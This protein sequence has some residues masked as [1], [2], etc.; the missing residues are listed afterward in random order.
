M[1][2][3]DKLRGETPLELLDRIRQERPELKEETLSYAGRLDPM[4]EGVMLILVG[5]QENADRKKHLGYDKIYTATFLAGVSTDTGDTL[6]LIARTKNTPINWSI[7]EKEIS[8]LKQITEQT[9]PWFSGKTVGGIK[10]FDHFKAGNTEINRPIQKVSIRDSSLISIDNIKSEE[11][12]KD[13][14][15]SIQKVSG[16]FRQEDI[17]NCW[18]EFFKDATKD[19]QVFKVDLHVS[20]G[21]FIR[22]L[23]EEFSFPTTLLKLRRTEILK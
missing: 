22:G 4:A 21:T 9:Y 12:R 3:V 14:E 15:S 10:L 1:L 5:K 13:I 2:L 17:L 8:D 7:L 20:S 23:A 19:M 11:V 16:D 6:G 18:K